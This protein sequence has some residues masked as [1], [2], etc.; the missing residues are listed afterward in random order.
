MVFVVI[1]SVITITE[2]VSN[3]YIVCSDRYEYGDKKCL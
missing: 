3:N 2:I 1:P